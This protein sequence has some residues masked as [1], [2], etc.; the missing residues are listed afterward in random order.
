[1]MLLE[2]AEKPRGSLSRR[3]PS[4]PKEVRRGGVGYGIVKVQSLI[5]SIIG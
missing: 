3:T 1:M 4:D 2:K 5:E